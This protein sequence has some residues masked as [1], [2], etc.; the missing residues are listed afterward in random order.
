MKCLECEDQGQYPK[1]P[2]CGKKCPPV[3]RSN[4]QEVIYLL[5]LDL[6]VEYQERLNNFNQ[7]CQSRYGRRKTCDGLGVCGGCP[8]CGKNCD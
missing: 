4:E 2:N 3:R 5:N 7:Q 1:C 6:G 8:T